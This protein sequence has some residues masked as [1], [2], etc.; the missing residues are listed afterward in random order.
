MDRLYEVDANGNR[1][2]IKHYK[3]VILE[4]EE[5]KRVWCNPPKEERRLYRGKPSLNEKTVKITFL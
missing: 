1:F 4:L 2:L 5:E 3:E